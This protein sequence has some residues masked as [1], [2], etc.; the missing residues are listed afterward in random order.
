MTKDKPRTLKQN[1]SLW[2]WAEMM[3]DYFNRHDQSVQMVLEHAFDRDWDK[4]VFVRVLFC[5]ILKHIT[6]D[7]STSKATTKEIIK[8]ANAIIDNLNLKM[9][10][11]VGEQV[12]RWPDRHSLAQERKA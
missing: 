6:D 5:P 1:S 7:G 12:P 10:H 3:S 8:T 9:S 4:D 11:I 2:K